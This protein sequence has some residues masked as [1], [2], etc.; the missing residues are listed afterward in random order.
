M[1]GV[2][3]QALAR[4]SG[5]TAKALSIGLAGPGERSTMKTRPACQSIMS[6]ASAGLEEEYILA[7]HMQ[8]FR[9]RRLACGTVGVQEAC[10]MARLDISSINMAG[11]TSLSDR[12]QGA[13][14][15]ATG[16]VSAANECSESRTQTG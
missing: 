6:I 3:G 16:L 9:L 13:L 14:R 10:A 4:D 2:A 8:A 11:D 1:V 5:A 12:S 7:E 15:M